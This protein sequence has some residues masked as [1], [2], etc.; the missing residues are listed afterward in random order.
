MPRGRGPI[1]FLDRQRK[2]Q[3]IEAILADYLVAPVRGYKILDVG[4]GNGGISEYLNAHNE[5][6]SVDVQDVRVNPDERASLSY[7]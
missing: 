4:S 5:V 3:M 6:F 1:K 2:A 7:K